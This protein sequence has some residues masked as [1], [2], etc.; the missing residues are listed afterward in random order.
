MNTRISAIRELDDVLVVGT[1]Q[2]GLL[3]IKGNDYELV[4]LGNGL[5]DINC[6][7]IF[8]DQ[9]RQIWLASFS[10]VFK[11][12][13]GANIHQYKVYQLNKF[14]GLLS[15]VVN[16]VVVVND[17]IYAASSAG[18]SA[19][20][21]KQLYNEQNAA[22]LVYIDAAFA[23][24]SGYAGLAAG[25]H[26]PQDSNNLEL[27][28]AAIDFSSTGNIL[29]KYRMNGNKNWQYSLNDFVRFE[30]LPHGKYVLEVMAMNAKKIWSKPASLLISID[31]YWWQ[32]VL[33]RFIALLIL[34]VLIFILVRSILSV[35]HQRELR[36]ASFRKQI[37]EI[38]L[39]AIKAQIN[40]HFIFNT[41]NAIQYFISNKQNDLAGDYLDRTASLLRN[42][43]DFSNKTAVTVKEEISFLENYV[44]LEKLRFEDNFVFTITNQ[45]PT[46][47]QDTEIPPM[48]LQPHIENALRHGLRDN[49]PGIKKLEINFNIAHEQLV[50]E[51]SD[52]GI[53]RQA[54]AAIKQG[55]QIKHL[56]MGMELSSSKLLLYEQLTGKKVKTEIIDKFENGA[57]S[58]TLI[59]ISININK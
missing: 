56:S 6:K 1:V 9:H 28:F 7:N 5:Q 46:D 41:L 42:T 39:K 50:C 51:I 8:I 53:G 14:S 35:K 27:R 31:P 17:T 30:S 58:G 49:N 44:E 54:S 21:V 12:D 40:P 16:D 43:L 2:K 52:N 57:P 38:E 10:G 24:G 11:I 18:I 20:P 37:I 23:N 4:Q 32:T 34:T 47:E 15:D 26:L 55:N 59:R 25:L 36:E 33:F 45:I 19:Y 29:F 22:P 13:P 3:L 48:V